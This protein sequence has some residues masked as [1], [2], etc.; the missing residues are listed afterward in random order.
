M[1]EYTAIE[2]V[3]TKMTRDA[4]P[5]AFLQILILTKEDLHA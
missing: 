2:N 4:L 3:P 5:K 1:K